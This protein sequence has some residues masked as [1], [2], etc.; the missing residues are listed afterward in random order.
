MSVKRKELYK[1]KVYII[2]FI[3]FSYSIYLIN[4]S[5]YVPNNSNKRFFNGDEVLLFSL[6]L[7][8]PYVN[9]FIWG[10]VAI[11]LTYLKFYKHSL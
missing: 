11:I 3:L 2:S 7:I 5:K 6:S 9:V 10:G 8:I 1:L 4:H